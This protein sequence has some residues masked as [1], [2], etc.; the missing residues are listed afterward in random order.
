M[1]NY[2][3]PVLKDSN[4]LRIYFENLSLVVKNILNLKI[5]N[6][7]KRIGQICQK[8][9]YLKMQLS[10]SNKITDKRRQLISVIW[11]IVPE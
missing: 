1:E 5:P 11:D 7:R 6:Q 3:V 8:I 10:L 2:K 9:N 4:Q